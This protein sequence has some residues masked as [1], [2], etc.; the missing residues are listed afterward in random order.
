[1]HRVQIHRVVC[2]KQLLMD[3]LLLTTLL[4]AYARHP[5]RCVKSAALSMALVRRFQVLPYV[6]KTILGN[7]HADVECSGGGYRA[8]PASQHRVVPL[9]CVWDV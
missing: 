3:S 5:R 9:Q 4:A 6:G 8:F 1:M 2:L 7:L